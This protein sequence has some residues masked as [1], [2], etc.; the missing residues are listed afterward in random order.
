V[1]D[2][3]LQQTRERLGAAGIDLPYPTRVLLFHDQTEE[4]DGNRADQREGWPKPADHDAPRPSK[5]AAALRRAT[6]AKDGPRSA[7]NGE[8]SH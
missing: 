2:R 7:P 4:T 6:E 8:R 5:I 3:V 1:K